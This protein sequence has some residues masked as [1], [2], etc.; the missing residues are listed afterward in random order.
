MIAQETVHRIEAVPFR[1]DVQ[2]LLESLQITDPAPF[3]DDI[4]HLVR[5]AEMVARPKGLYK[6]AAVDAMGDDAVAIDAVAFT[7]RILRVNIDGLHRVFP[8]V[9]TCGLEIEQWS[10]G[11]DDMMKQFCAD[12]I[13]E[14]ALRRAVAEL[15]RHLNETYHPSKRAAMNPG[16]LEDWPLAQQRPLFGLF[17]DVAGLIGVELGD[18]FLMSPIKSVSGIWFETDKDYH[19]CR[20][21]PREQ[22]PN[23][24]APYEP[25]LL[26]GEYGL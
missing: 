8:F 18:T 2:A 26:E 6:L 14:L 22:C 17:G 25:H 4:G 1:V 9:A 19:N 15:A 23:R 5:E 11:L 16:S 7:S 20:L 12:A 21:C 10:R 24:R 13:K 3:M